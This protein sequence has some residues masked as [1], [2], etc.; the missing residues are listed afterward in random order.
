MRQYTCRLFRLVEMGRDALGVPVKNRDACGWCVVTPAPTKA[1][2][3][4]TDGNEQLYVRR[5]FRTRKD[6]DGFRCVRYFEVRGQDY[7]LENVT[8]LG[9]EGS[10]ITGSYRR[11]E[12]CDAADRA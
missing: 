11:P 3:D 1:L 12:V 8:S 5:T 2:E 6:A 9:A 7:K 10:L 4:A